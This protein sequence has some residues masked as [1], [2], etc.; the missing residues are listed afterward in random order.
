[1]DLSLS[2]KVALVTGSSRGIGRAIAIELASQGA[3]V[4]IH[5]NQTRAL[6]NKVVRE[7]K[8][9]GGQALYLQANITQKK[10]CIE[11][12]KK[13][14]KHFGK[15]DI[16]V[17]NA[18]IAKSSPFLEMPEKNWDLVLDTNLNSLFYITQPVVA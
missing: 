17:N 15:I 8:D 5:S 18:G 12:V 14:I 10:Q 13:A 4:V 16:L 3:K 1:M 11:L 6:G 9:L 2:G 7:I